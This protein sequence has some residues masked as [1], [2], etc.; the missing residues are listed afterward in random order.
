MIHSLDSAHFGVPLGEKLTD[1]VN[2]KRE[3]DAV[4]RHGKER[5]AAS[6]PA[7]LALDYNYR[8][9]PRSPAAARWVT[10]SEAG[11]REPPAS[12]LEVT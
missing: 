8:L 7:S 1:A 12:R 10:R 11:N 2:L 4:A 9:L 6:R 3:V 5:I